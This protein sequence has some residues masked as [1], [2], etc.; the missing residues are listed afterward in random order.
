[1]KCAAFIL[2]SCTLVASTGLTT[3]ARTQ[4]DRAVVLPFI[5]LTGENSLYWIG[6]LPKT[7]QML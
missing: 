5:N 1:M 3:A 4:D 7:A 6:H 2:M